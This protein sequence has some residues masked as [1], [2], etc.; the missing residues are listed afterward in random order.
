MILIIIIDFS[1]W[2][3]SDN[4]II[5]AAVVLVAIV[6]IIVWIYYRRN[7]NKVEYS[8]LTSKLKSEDK[9]ENIIS[10]G[11]L[12]SQAQNLP[13]NTKREIKRSCFILESELGHGNF[14]QVHKGVLK[15]LY[16][17]NSSTPVAI[18]SIQKYGDKQN[19]RDFICEIKLMSRI[20]PHP[21]LVSM[22]GS[23][24]SELSKH[25]KLWLLLEFCENGDLKNYLQNNKMEITFGNES[26]QIN[27]R[28]LLKWSYGIAK[29]MHY[30][31]QNQIM[32]G[33]LAARNVLMSEDPLKSKCLLVKIADFG[34]AK[35]I[36]G[37]IN[38]E[39]KSRLL[40]PWKWMALEY[41]KQDFFTLKSDVWS[42]GVLLWE[43]LS[44]GSN[45]YGQL[46]YDEVIEKLERGYRLPCPREADHCESW[47]PV[48]LYNQLSKICFLA[49]PENR[50]SFLDVVRV[51][52]NTLSSNEKKCYEQMCE[53]YEST[54]AVNY[55]KIGNK[56][57]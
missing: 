48:L 22:I 5:A 18:K 23:C 19:L 4:R 28:C 37:D 3:I 9:S 12:K 29:G 33:D 52:E 11:D 10:N 41:L 8:D 55:L 16:S 34:L 7:K 42:F 20:K 27:S 15:G 43:I 35:K 54:R 17:A 47:S 1:N 56:S 44:F 51:I 21:N 24:S 2:L 13:Y 50:A 40:V 53:V 45:P 6:I 32:H 25:G 26:D 14:G 38:Y 36:Y 57:K 49:D 39:K 31:A 46:D 30:L